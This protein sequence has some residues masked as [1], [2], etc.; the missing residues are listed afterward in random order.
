MKYYVRHKFG[1]SQHYN[2]FDQHTW[3]GA[4][5]GAADAA[6]WYIVLLDMLIDAYHSRIA[7]N[8]LHDPMKMIPVLR[9]LK[10][11]IDDVVLHATDGPYAS[12]D[13]L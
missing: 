5:Q 12:L 1:V 2:T 6:L 10:A 9:S 7:P 8:S 11:F 3:H 13:N 4:G